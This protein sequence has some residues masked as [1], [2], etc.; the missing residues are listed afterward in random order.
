MVI[1]CAPARVTVSGLVLALAPALGRLRRAAWL[2]VWL[3]L[4]V[5]GLLYLLARP[6]GIRLFAWLEAAGLGASVGFARDVAYPI[7][8]WLP[9]WLRFSL[10]NALWVYAFAWLLSYVWAHRPTRE[11]VPWL[12]V[13]PGLA[14]GWEVGQLT[15]LVPG[16]F[17]VLDLAFVL[18]ASVLALHQPLS[19]LQTS[20]PR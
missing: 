7:A 12:L 2:H 8:V 9:A 17:D 3:P 6:T 4:V 16:T 5:G 19:R 11:S 14:I 10:P 20:L 13:A 15:G 1:C 18:G